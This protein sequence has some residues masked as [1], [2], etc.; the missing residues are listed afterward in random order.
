M[1]RF[2]IPSLTRCAAWALVALVA[3]TS[4]LLAQR[5]RD[6]FTEEIDVVTV[7]VPVQVLAD[8]QPV[9]GLKRENFEIY[10]GR[11][12]QVITG[13]DV[14]DLRADRPANL[15]IQNIPVSARRH[16]LL[17]FD[18]SF[19]DPSV[20]SRARRA[21]FD[22]VE[23]EFH[24]TDVVA[25]AT[26]SLQQGPQLVL[27][28]TPDR[29]QIELAIETLG[30]PG[31]LERAA[32]PL[33]F[34]IADTA[35]TSQRA[36]TDSDRVGN[37]D[38][39]S[40]FAANIQDYAVGF[41]RAERGEAQGRV[42]ALT[43]AFEDLAKAMGD[44]TGRK[45]VVYLSEGFD[46]QVV[47]GSDDFQRRQ[48]VAR[49]TAEGRFWE[50]DSEEMYGS[51]GTLTGLEKMLEAFRRAD[52]TIQAVDIGGLRA[53]PDAAARRSGQDSLFMMANSTGGE[54]YRNFNDLSG[55]MGKMLERTSVT[56]VLAFQADDVKFDGDFHKLR[57]E[58][59]GDVPRGAKVVHKPGFYAPRPY[60][61]RSAIQKRLEAAQQILS[62]DDAGVLG[63]SVVAAPFRAE[64]G[65]AYVP[66]LIEIDGPSLLAG[67]RGKTA[68]LE[69][70]AYAIAEDGSVGDFMTQTMGLDVEKVR[71]ALEASGLK[72][73]GDLDLPPGD[74]LVRVLVRE[75][76]SGR[77]A[78]R[79]VPVMVPEF[80]SGFPTLAMPLFPEEPGKW[81]MV[82][83]TAGSEA[84]SAR[85][86]PFV[87]DGNAYLPAAKPVIQAGGS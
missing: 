45:H 77:S 55:A 67:V 25:V 43:T 78:T 33:A 40:L 44:V 21:A 86:F 81:L 60:K 22:L 68:A 12:R 16:F 70:Y 13:F 30:L 52:C 83:E 84:R 66:V 76:E 23:K 42:A 49:A 7:E 39:E 87:L 10:D 3:S 74:Y 71:P 17:L 61:D 27:G 82:Q 63:A 14:V 56:Y 59:K 18:L 65:R 85:P 28:F 64:A 53:G 24:P 73:F 5:N 19:S 37:V 20:I 15:P 48:E 41:D 34:V 8:G 75:S 11:K 62:G 50:S 6:R 26:Y 4:A 69:I 72:F 80:G 32:D 35:L 2:Q 46:A 29:R 79:A 47:L 9:T 58:L 1:N 31:L 54:L 36:G 51:T 57:I 38:L